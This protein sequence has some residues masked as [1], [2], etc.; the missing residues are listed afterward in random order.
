MR[1]EAY[2]GLGKPNRPWTNRDRVLAGGLV[3]LEQSLNAHGIPSWVA[4][5]PDRIFDV[6]E[7]VDHAAALVEDTQAE[8]ASN[9][10]ADT[11][12]LR[13]TVQDKGPRGSQLA[14]E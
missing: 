12:G 3:Y 1:P 13:I 5:D 8:Y 7:V 2:L 4:Q 6:D 14:G 9:P 11:H 10:T